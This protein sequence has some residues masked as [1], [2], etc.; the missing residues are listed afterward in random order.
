MEELTKTEARR[1]LGSHFSVL[2]RHSIWM[3]KQTSGD[4]SSV[5]GSMDETYHLGRHQ[6]IDGF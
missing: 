1:Q 5:E 3:F 4:R 2:I 6:C